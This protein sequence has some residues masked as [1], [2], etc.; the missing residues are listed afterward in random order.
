MATTVLNDVKLLR[1]GYDLSG[2]S[3]RFLAGFGTEALDDTGFGNGGARAFLPGLNTAAFEH[4]GMVDLGAGAYEDIL[5]SEQGTADLPIT[6]AVPGAAGDLAYLFRGIPSQLTLGGQVGELYAFSVSAQGS[7][8]IGRGLVLE[9][10]STARTATFDGSVFELA[11]GPASG[12]FLYATLHVLSASAADTLDVVIESD[13]NDDMTSAT[14]RITFTQASAVGSEWKALA[15]P[16][17]DE[18][19]R[20]AVT[21]G[22][23]DPSFS[24]YVAIGIGR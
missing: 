20:V 17:T 21:I 9:D 1:G 2:K 6:V 16:V 14:S 19:Y 10:G 22:G 15:G 23:T 13:D 11:A 24:F 18:F 12:Q 5:W 3:N 4:A 7:G 8:A